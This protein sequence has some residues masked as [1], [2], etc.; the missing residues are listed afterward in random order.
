MNGS[1]PFPRTV[2]YLGPAGTYSEAAALSLFPPPG[3]DLERDPQTPSPTLL[4]HNTITATLKAVVHGE[5]DLGIV[6]VE[7]SIEGGVS[8]TLDGFWQL[9]GL[10]IRHALIRPI[11]HA[12]IGQAQDP[13][14]IQT[15]YSHP[16]ALAQCQTWI[17]T[18][19]PQALQ[20]ATRST[21]E[22]MDQVKQQSHTALIASERAAELHQLPILSCPINDHPNNCT[23]FWLVGLSPIPQGTHT[24]L[25]FSLPQNAPGALLQ[26]L[27]IFAQRGLNLSRIESRPTKQ[28]VGTYVFFVDVEH[29][30]LPHLPEEVIQELQG[31]TDV[32]KIFGCYSV[33]D[34]TGASD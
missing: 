20:V 13:S 4:P 19:L 6:P 33:V 12:L 11:R 24:S 31:S 7:N 29:P 30:E 23:R 17:Q 9:D 28:V 25:A 34:A 2:A 32:L 27:K 21:T 18:H 15:L 22:E 16:Q 8:M 5:V 3:S 14:Q 1:A 26:P 10:Q